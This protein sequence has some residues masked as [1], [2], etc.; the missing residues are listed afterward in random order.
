MYLYPRWKDLR[1]DAELKQKDIAKLLMTSQQQYCRYETGEREIP[2]H[3]LITL[4]R[5]YKV[6]ADYILGLTNKK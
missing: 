6:S 2:A 5:F 4:A 3:H 1:E